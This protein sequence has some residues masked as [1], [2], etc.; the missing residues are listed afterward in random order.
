MKKKIGILTGFIITIV[1]ALFIADGNN[2][3]AETNSCTTYINYYLMLDAVTAKFYT[4]DYCDTAQY[5]CAEG[6]GYKDG[7]FVTINSKNY[8]LGVPKN[9]KILNE[10]VVEVNTTASGEN[11]MTFSKFYE[12]YDKGGDNIAYPSADSD[13]KY[14]RAVTYTS[15]GEVKVSEVPVESFAIFT[16]QIPEEQCRA[17]RDIKFNY[18]EKG[19]SV[20]ITRTWTEDKA[21]CI[22]NNDDFY[23]SDSTQPD[24]KK[25]K[26]IFDPVAYYV[27]YEVCNSVTINYVDIDTGNEVAE[28]YE[29]DIEGKTSYN[30]TCPNDIEGYELDDTEETNF[31]GQVNGVIEHTCYYKKSNGYKVK[32][33]FI[34]DNTKKEIKSTTTIASELADGSNFEYTCKDDINY[35]SLITTEKQVG[36]INGKDVDLYCNYNKKKMTLTINYGTDLN[37]TDAGVIRKSE[38]NDYE[39]G[40]K[41]QHTIPS[42]DGYEFSQLGNISKTFENPPVVTK[43]SFSFTM[44]AKNTSIC[45]VYIKNSQTGSGWIYFAWILGIGALAYSIYYFTRYLKNNEA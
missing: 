27:K 21:S 40:T 38:T 22:Y 35:Y 23:V 18:D 12:V 25:G 4:Q 31:S 19:A 1:I 2:V 45:L 36:K 10:G 30:Y 15:G 29:L 32:V 7:V 44:P 20:S 41:I 34:D 26:S 6:N 3:K 14:I 9:A 39:W 13:V 28:P 17:S 24:G 5:G 43:D 16:S 42:I 11:K 37:C 33:H 8:N